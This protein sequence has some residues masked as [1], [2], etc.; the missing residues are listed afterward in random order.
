LNQRTERKF[1]LISEIEIEFA[2]RSGEDEAIGEGHCGIDNEDSLSWSSVK[3]LYEQIPVGKIPLHGFQLYNAKGLGVGW[4]HYCWDGSYY[5]TP[6]DVGLDAPEMCDPRV[7]RGG[8]WYY[9]N[10]FLGSTYPDDTS[11]LPNRYIIFG[12]RLA[13]DER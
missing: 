9:Q 12:I 5:V 2:C 10:R 11:I 13:Y 4:G 1:R 3:T 7:L 6:I 8:A